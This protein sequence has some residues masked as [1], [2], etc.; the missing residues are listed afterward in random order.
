MTLF[1]LAIEL[2][3]CSNS[4]NLLAK[5]VFIKMNAIVCLGDFVQALKLG[6]WCTHL[7]PKVSRFHK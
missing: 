4:N 2:A 5:S 1:L 6:V 7:R 3:D